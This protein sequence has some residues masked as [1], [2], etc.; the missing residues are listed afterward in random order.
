MNQSV[1][2]LEFI[3]LRFFL[4]HKPKDALADSSVRLFAFALLFSF[5]TYC[6]YYPHY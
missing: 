3:L 1:F 5:V 2:G 6:F 4:L